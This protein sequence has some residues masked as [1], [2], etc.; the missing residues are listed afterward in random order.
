MVDGLMI[1]YETRPPNVRVFPIGD[2]S[3][4]G[5]NIYLSSLGAFGRMDTIIL[6][7]LGW[8]KCLPPVDLYWSQLLNL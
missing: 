6:P 7:R 5:K 3:Y 1:A 2:T 8:L 4:L